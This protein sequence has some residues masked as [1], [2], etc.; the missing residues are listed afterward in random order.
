MEN[1]SRPWNSTNPVLAKNWPRP[2][3]R[4]L[5]PKI[6]CLPL[7]TRKSSMPGSEMASWRL[8]LESC[9]LE[10]IDHQILLRF[11]NVQADRFV[12]PSGDGDLHLFQHIARLLGVQ[13]I[14]FACLHG[15]RDV[16]RGLHFVDCQRQFL[17]INGRIHVIGWRQPDAALIDKETVVA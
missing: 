2:R 15:N 8:R 14:V 16:T 7:S 13:P 12:P 1:A 3:L 11:W 10:C 9:G 17:T 6:S 4:N 5:Q